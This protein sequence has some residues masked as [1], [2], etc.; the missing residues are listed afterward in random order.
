[1]A[2]LVQLVSD[3]A[4]TIR[5]VDSILL[6]ISSLRRSVVTKFGVLLR[7]AEERLRISI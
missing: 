2:R 5:A 4:M 7:Q 1:M 6:T 3:K